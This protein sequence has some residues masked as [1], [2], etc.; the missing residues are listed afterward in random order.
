[1]PSYGSH[2]M[3]S[4]WAPCQTTTTTTTIIIIILLMKLKS[5]HMAALL[6]I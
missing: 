6:N 2:A 3:L 1:M 4:Q 5:Y